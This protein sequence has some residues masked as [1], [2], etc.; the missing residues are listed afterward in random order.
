MTSR[1]VTVTYIRATPQS[2]W[3]ALITP[4]I[5]RRY[6]NGSFPESSWELGAPWTLILPDGRVAD[7]GVV[8]AFE[9]P[10]RLSVS[11]RSELR[12]DLR[13]E[14]YARCLWVIEPDEGD[15]VKLVVTH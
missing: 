8:L 2:V 7:M 14:G 15:V 4:D 12:D 6:W 10:A 9:P 3:E 13:A 11:W 1:L 5:V